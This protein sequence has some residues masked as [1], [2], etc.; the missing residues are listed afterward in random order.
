[1]PA[2]IRTSINK[3]A[4][5]EKPM[6]CA[7][8]KRPS[9]DKACHICLFVSVAD[10]MLGCLDEYEV[11]FAPGKSSRACHSVLFITY[12]WQWFW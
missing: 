7:T 1:M 6:G 5:C 9:A 4:L 11:R 10:H 3:L 2:G 8:D 12:S